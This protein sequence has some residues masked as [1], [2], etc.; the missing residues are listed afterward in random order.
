M[1]HSC[2]CCCLVAAP[3]GRTVPGVLTAAPL[4]ARAHHGAWRA[5][6][7]HCGRR[8]L[9]GV[10]VGFLLGLD[11][12]LLVADPLVPKPVAHLHAITNGISSCSKEVAVIIVIIVVVIVCT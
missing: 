4:A 7:R 11:D 10:H 1:I 2:V 12:V 6:R 9:G 8:G 5:A 3:V